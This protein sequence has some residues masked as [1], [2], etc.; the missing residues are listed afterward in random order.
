[1]LLT[2]SLALP[3]SQASSTSSL[4]ACIRRVCSRHITFEALYYPK[5]ETGWLKFLNA[6]R[7]C[8]LTRCGY[9]GISVV[10]LR[11]QVYESRFGY[12]FRLSKLV[13][14]ANSF[15]ILHLGTKE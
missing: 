13:T 11:R 7:R 15:T 12:N 4:P 1:M 3:T 6:K 2:F 14:L 9:F 5:E 10:D 8:L